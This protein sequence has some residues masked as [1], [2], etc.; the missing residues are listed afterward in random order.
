MADSEARRDAWRKIGLY[1]ALTFTF[2]A[3]FYTLIIRAGDL[4]AA[5]G[6]YVLLLMWSPG[7]A[8]ILTRLILQGNLR[9]MGWRWGK[10]RWQVLAY[11]LPIGYA[12][13]AY[14]AVWYTG[15]GSPSGPR[16]GSVWQFV[17]VGSLFSIRSATGEEIGWRGLL[18]PELA[19]VTSFTGTAVISGLIWAS[20][21][22]PL[23]VFANY[24][25]GTPWWYSTLCFVVLVV[26]I[27]VPLA[28]LRLKSGSLWTGA[29]LHASHN[30]YIQGYFDPATVDTGPTKWVI[31]EFGAALAIVAVAVAVIFWRLRG[32]LGMG[33][34][35]DGARGAVAAGAAGGGGAGT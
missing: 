28:W 31:G 9:G 23:I 22:V 25:G 7:T 14:L 27:S 20:W 6:W 4:G 35:T 11:L 10:T 32:R 5:G 13:V 18:V 30:L 3:V 12:S 17:L 21:H 1:L 24:N 26:G 2:S 34:A 16:P 8:A 19:R 33:N 29:L 15:L